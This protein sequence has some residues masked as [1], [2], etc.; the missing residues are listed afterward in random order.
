MLCSMAIPHL[1]S[2]NYLSIRKL[3]KNNHILKIKEKNGRN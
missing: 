3:S 1:S 2:K